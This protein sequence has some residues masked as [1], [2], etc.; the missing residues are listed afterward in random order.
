M[1]ICFDQISH[2][3]S[4]FYRVFNVLVHLGL[5]SW[6]MNVQQSA[7][8]DSNLAEA[9]DQLDKMVEYTEQGLPNPSV[10]ADG[11]PCIEIKVRGLVRIRML[12]D[13]IC[14]S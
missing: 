3:L 9:A 6:T 1:A 13:H 4:F 5:K 7:W 14:L 8:T 12:F 11:T 10:L 2:L